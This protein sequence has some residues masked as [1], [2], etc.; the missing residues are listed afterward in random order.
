MSKALFFDIDG[1]LVSFKTHT[2]PQSTRDALKKL[3]A[4]GHKIFIATG[5]PKLLISQ[6]CNLGFDGYVT[7]NGAHCFN[8]N[9][10]DIYKGTIPNEDIEKLI[11]YY[12]THSY[13]FLCILNNDWFI[14][15]SNKDVEEICRLIEI[16]TPPIAPLE[17]ARG[18]EVLEIMGYFPKQV[19]EE[20]F[21]DIL[22]HCEP[23]RWHPLFTDIVRKGI[24]KSTGIDEMINYYGF[25]LKDTIAF[26]DGGNDMSMLKHVNMGIAMGN[27]NERVKAVADYVTSTVDDDGIVNALKHLKLI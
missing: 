11:A 17:T 20:V 19:E 12:G 21:K 16:K 8:D 3:K 25:D 23:L 2:I 5:R 4:N 9:N 26:G 27:A 13:P 14:T 1:T 15:H 22:T 7:M 18:K 10:I 6:F 24:S